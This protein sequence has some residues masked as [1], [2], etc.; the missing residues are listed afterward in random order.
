MKIVI[1][2]NDA[3]DCGKDGMYIYDYDHESNSKKL[4]CWIETLPCSSVWQADLV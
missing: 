4:S 3:D 2:I 1:I